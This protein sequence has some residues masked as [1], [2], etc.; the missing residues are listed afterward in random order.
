MKFE[1]VLKG[2]LAAA[3]CLTLA[4]CESSGS[5]ASAG[6][7]AESAATD[8]EGAGDLTSFTIGTKTAPYAVLTV[9]WLFTVLP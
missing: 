2:G 9:I 1:K 8:Y 4:A 6:G 7:S 3:M 5:A